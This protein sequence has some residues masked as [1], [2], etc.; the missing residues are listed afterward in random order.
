[1]PFLLIGIA[2]VLLVTAFR[3]TFGA[4]FSAL[5]QDAGPYLKWAAALVLVA[6]V[7]WIPGLKPVSRAL[8]A[9]VLVVLVLGNYKALFSQ[10]AAVS[11]GAPPSPSV[12]QN[13]PAQAV[14]AGGH[15]TG[16][17][18]AGTD[19]GN[20]NA[21]QAAAVQLSPFDPVAL[22]ASYEKQIGFG[23]VA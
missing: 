13:D 18:V 20:V 7:G 16:E 5:G 3:N 11:T 4:L 15:V 21:N 2:A 1:V 9:L 8:L 6:A 23:G 14:V 22:L 12:A 19:P 10:L 17:Q